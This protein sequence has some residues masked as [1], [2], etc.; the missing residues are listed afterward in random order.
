MRAKKDSHFLPPW[1]T[2]AISAKCPRSGGERRWC[3]RLWPQMPALRV[4]E[5]LLTSDTKLCLITEFHS[6]SPPVLPI[7]P[8]AHL[9]P[10]S[11]PRPWDTPQGGLLILT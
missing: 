11:F 8:A 7:P 2:T 9:H 4:E 10:P 5:V 1:A 3:G 6:P